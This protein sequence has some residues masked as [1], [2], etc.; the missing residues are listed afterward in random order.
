M[1]IGSDG[2]SP[3]RLRLTAPE[4]CFFIS[5]ERLNCFV[6]RQTEAIVVLGG[7]SIVVLGLLPTLTG[8]RSKKWRLASLRPMMVKTIQLHRQL[9]RAEGNGHINFI[10]GPGTLAGGV[11]P[12]LTGFHPG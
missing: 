12:D 9:S 10:G 4:F 11:Q 8:L 5:S 7:G 2:A 3:W 1:T 6:F